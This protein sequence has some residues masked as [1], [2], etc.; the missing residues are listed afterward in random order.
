VVHPAVA[1]LAMML[2]GLSN[3]FLDVAGYTLIQ[4]TT[5]NEARIAVLGLTDGIANLGPAAGGL[6]A[7]LLIGSLGVQGALVLTGAILPI[8]AVVLGSMTRD[9]DAGGPAAARR[10]E[11]LRGQPLFAPLS[12]ATV[13]HLAATM[14]PRHFDTGSWLM[15]EGDPGDDYLLI[16]TGEVEISQGGHILRTLGAGHGVGEI[17]LI[18]DIPRTA[19]VRAID[20]VQAFSLDRDAFLEAVTGHAGSHAAARNVAGERLALDRARDG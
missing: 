16:D 11:L 12:L 8:A 18:N 13:E 20:A 2:V 10:V 7:P 19:S 1:I 9:V 15:W 17:A 6:V 4:R 3:A 5:P 14:T